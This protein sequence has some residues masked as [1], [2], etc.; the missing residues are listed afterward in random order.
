MRKCNNCKEWIPREYQFCPVCGAT[1]SKKTAKANQS[2]GNGSG[3][4]IA[5]IIAIIFAIIGGISYYM[6]TQGVFGQF[7]EQEECDT[8]QMWSDTITCDQELP[9]RLSLTSATFRNNLMVSIDL[10]ITPS[11]KV[12]GTFRE[13]DGNRT[14]NISGD[15]DKSTGEIIVKNAQQDLRMTLTPL[16][17]AGNYDCHWYYKGKEDYAYFYQTETEQT[18]SPTEKAV[19]KTDSVAIEVDNIA[20]DEELDTIGTPADSIGKKTSAENKV[21]QQLKKLKLSGTM[22]DHIEIKMNLFDLEN[23]KG[24]YYYVSQGPTRIL[25][26]KCQKDDDGNIIMTETDPNG[27]ATGKFKGR[28][29]NGKFK[30]GFTNSKGKE[31][32]VTL[33]SE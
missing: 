33:K 3:C 20:S 25:T 14:F 21:N 30:G 24:E 7:G 32:P 28:I 22:G 1:Q 10:K 29:E 9:S 15:A 23:G 31:F 2:S 16:G 27:K 6:Y 13:H 4:Y 26:L 12:T 5:V 18:E 19:E 17:G 11:G 8:T